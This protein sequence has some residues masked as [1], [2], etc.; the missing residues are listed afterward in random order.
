MKQGSGSRRAMGLTGTDLKWVAMAAML[1]DHIGAVILER[2]FFYTGTGEMINSAVYSLDVAA[3]LLGRTAF[4]IFCFLLVEGFVYTRSRKKYFNSLLLFSVISEIP[5]NL[6]LSGRVFYPESQNVFFTLSIG[7]IAMVLYERA[8]NARSSG[9]KSKG[10]A[11]ALGTAACIVLAELLRTDYGSF[12]VVLI[13]IFYALR[14]RG[15]ER[16]FAAGV[17]LFLGYAIL[18]VITMP[19]TFFAFLRDYGIAQSIYLFLGSGITEGF[20][21]LSFVFLRKYNGERGAL[22]FSK[23]LFYIFYPVHLLVLA[24]ISNFIT[25]FLIQ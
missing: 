2:C 19:G 10:F 25:S 16:F 1:I 7:L 14:E 3:R 20:G 11:Y 4:P 23:Y 5:F 12:G 21:I 18:N 6:A 9:K 15:E 17:W 22:P 13:L 8:V 24:C